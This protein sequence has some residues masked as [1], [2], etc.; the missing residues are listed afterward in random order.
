MLA[1]FGCNDQIIR[2]PCWR[3]AI[4][5]LTR[6]ISLENLCQPSVV[7]LCVWVLA[8]IRGNETLFPIVPI[9]PDVNTTTTMW[10][11]CFPVYVNRNNCFKLKYILIV[12][13]DT[14]FLSPNISSFLWSKMSNLT[15]QETGISIHSIFSSTLKYVHWIDNL[16]LH[17]LGI[18]LL[19]SFHVCVNMLARYYMSSKT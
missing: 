12:S 13:Q 14:W 5:T 10:W 8:F 15:S 9:N 7:G 6:P 3:Q 18:C 2:L 1:V 17:G 4:K 11:G 19:F 16:F